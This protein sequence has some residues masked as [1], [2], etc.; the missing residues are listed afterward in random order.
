MQ[1]TQ[2]SR[3]CGLTPSCTKPFICLLLFLPPY[4]PD[5]NPI[6]NTFAKVKLQ[7]KSCDKAIQSLSEDDFPDIQAAG[8]KS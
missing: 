8:C 4:S 2:N 7:L 3:S 5:L 6:E 1:I